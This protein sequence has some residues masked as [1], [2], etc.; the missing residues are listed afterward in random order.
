MSRVAGDKMLRMETSG[1]GMY[2]VLKELSG[3]RIRNTRDGQCIE[4]NR[5]LPRIGGG[6]GR[7]S[8]GCESPALIIDGVVQLMGVAMLLTLPI[9]DIESIEYMNSAEIG[10]RFPNIP[11]GAIVIWT[12]GNGPHQSVAR[13]NWK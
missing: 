11:N 7:G 12:R 1:V 10:V 3:I 8:A 9:A 6:G 4:T 2:S 13:T 5:T